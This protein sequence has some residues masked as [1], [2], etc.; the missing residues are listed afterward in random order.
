MIIGLA[1]AAALSGQGAPAGEW[2]SHG[3][4]ET[5]EFFTIAARRGPDGHP[6]VWVRFEYD[7]PTEFQ[8]Q[9]IRSSRVLS[10]YDCA[11]SQVRNLQVAN[12]TNPGLTGEGFRGQTT[13]AWEYVPPAT[14]DEYVLTMVCATT[15]GE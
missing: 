7:R 10:E 2:T 5:L 12:Y 14:I 6:R 11:E 13:L 3:K 4:S 15:S 1:M 8:G 9:M